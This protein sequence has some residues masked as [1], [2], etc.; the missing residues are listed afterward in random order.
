MGFQAESA[1]VRCGMIWIDII[2]LVLS[3]IAA[4]FSIWSFLLERKRNRREA[5]IHAFEELE[6]EVFLQDDYESVIAEAKKEAEEHKSDRAWRRGT[7]LLA[8]I[9]HFCVG[10]QAKAFDL[11]TLN[12]LAGG[13]FIKQYENW[14]PIIEQKRLDDKSMKHYNEFEDVVNKLKKKRKTNSN[15][16]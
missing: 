16:D 8:R 13:Y 2:A 4:V 7:E 1:G 6:K 12:R 5:T 9:E 11:D 3:A 10:V 15:D 14:R